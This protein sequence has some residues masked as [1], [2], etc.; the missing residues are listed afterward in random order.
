MSYK[1]KLVVF[2]QEIEIIN[3][4]VMYERFFDNTTGRCKSGV[5]GGM[6]QVEVLSSSNDEL[7][8]QWMT[9]SKEDELCTLTKGEIAFYEGSFDIPS[10]FEYKFNDA[11]LVNYREVFYSNGNHPMTIQLMIS[12]A[13]QEFKGQTLIKNWHQSQVEPVEAAISSQEEKTQDQVKIPEIIEVYWIDKQGKKITKARYGD[14]VNVFV[15]TKGMVAGEVLIMDF[16]QQGKTF[17]GKVKA[18]GSARLATIN[19]DKE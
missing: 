16:K 12:P 11:A 9:E 3:V 4:E 5:M 19:L 7:L 15:K 1:A 6:I 18:D 2:G 14:G 13:I 8:L 17:K 10:A